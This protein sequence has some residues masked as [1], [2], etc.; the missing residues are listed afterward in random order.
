MSNPDIQYF[1]A[2][3][4]WVKP[5]RAAAV[6]IVLRGG[7]GGDVTGDRGG[8]GGGASFARLA[9][10]VIPATGNVAPASGTSP[11]SGRLGVLSYDAAD[12]PDAVEVEVGKGGRPARTTPASPSSSP[13]STGA[14]CLSCSPMRRAW[15]APTCGGSPG[16]QPV[17]STSSS[18]GWRKQAG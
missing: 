14:G 11:T 9:S 8:D 2:S 10:E 5:E 1:A 15:A 6:D 18:P 12:L 13:V 17:T 7:D 3:G 4:T 16:A